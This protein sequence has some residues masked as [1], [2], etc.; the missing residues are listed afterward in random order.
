MG[1]FGIGQG[2]PRFEDP[3]LVRGHGF[4]IDDVAYPGM[5]YGVV[6]RSP[7]AYARIKSIDTTAAK[8]A[9]GVLEVLTSADIKAAGYGDLPGNPGLKRRGGAPLD[10]A[11]VG[12]LTGLPL[13][14]I[15][16]LQWPD[17]TDEDAVACRAEYRTIYDETVIPATRLFDGARDAL[18]DFHAAGLLQATVTGKR[19]ADCERI[20]R[21]L[22]I[23]GDIDLY[24][25]GDSVPADRH[26]PAPDLVLLAMDRLGV[27]PERTAVVG[28]TRTDM[29][30]GRAAGARTIQVLWGYERTPVAEADLVVATWAALRARILTG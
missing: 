1:E 23:E 25:G 3:K 16:R 17:L 19:A 8:A 29:R 28:D 14:H 12:R 4:F 6:L 26:K 24:L 15:F 10:F 20:L 30:M 5:A 27:E 2:V 13:E 21:G 22:S 7:H 11:L 18:R 9:P